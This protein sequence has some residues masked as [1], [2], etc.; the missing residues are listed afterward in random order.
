MHLV[1]YTGQIPVSA[2]KKNDDNIISFPQ[3][4]KLQVL[5]LIQVKYVIIHK[6]YS[7]NL[8]SEFYAYIEER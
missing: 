4:K 3:G 8:Q 5:I 2:H 1:V 6:E 7:Y